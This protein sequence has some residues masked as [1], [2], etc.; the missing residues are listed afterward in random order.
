MN[1]D[2]L[3]SRDRVVSLLETYEALLTEKQREIMDDY[4]RFDLSLGEISSSREISRAGAYDTIKKSID[5]LEEYEAKLQLI[6]K[7]ADLCREIEK[8]ETEKDEDKILEGYR[9][10]G[11]ELTNGI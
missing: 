4:Y 6:Q 7:K 9:T 3:S 11:M 5:K 10:L 8:I 1:E 2:A